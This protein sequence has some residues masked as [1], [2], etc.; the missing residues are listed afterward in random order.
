MSIPPVQ[1]AERDATELL[2]GVKDSAGQIYGATLRGATEA[3]KTGRQERKTRLLTPPLDTPHVGSRPRL[4]LDLLLRHVL[5][6]VL[7]IGCPSQTQAFGEGEITP[8]PTT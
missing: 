7:F 8:S 4:P 6:A 2:L 5:E 3:V 1:S